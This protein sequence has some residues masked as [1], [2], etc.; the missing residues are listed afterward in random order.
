MCKHFVLLFFHKLG[1]KKNAEVLT[2]LGRN[3]CVDLMPCSVIQ[4]CFQCTFHKI[5]YWISFCMNMTEKK[6]FCLLKV[7]LYKKDALFWGDSS[8]TC[9]LLLGQMWVAC[10][11]KIKYLCR[12]LVDCSVNSSSTVSR[13]ALKHSHVIFLAQYIA[14]SLVVSLQ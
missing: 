2:S 14:K 8:C 10:V 1:T 7:R 9:A 3:S 6:R 5:M 12:L 13:S 11:D 4:K